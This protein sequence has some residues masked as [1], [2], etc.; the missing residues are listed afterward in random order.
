MEASLVHCIVKYF[1][2]EQ[3]NL[4]QAPNTPEQMG[5]KCK[6]VCQHAD[7]LHLGLTDGMLA[8]VSLK[9]HWVWFD[10]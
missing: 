9:V 3:V 1:H 7:L 4:N 5:T 2:Q 8:S 10:E 6:F